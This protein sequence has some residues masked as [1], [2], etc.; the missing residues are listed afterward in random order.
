[1]A[2]LRL[3]ASYGHCM[4][5]S[6]PCH[7]AIE[8]GHMSMSAPAC[9]AVSP[10]RNTWTSHCLGMQAGLTTATRRQRWWCIRKHCRRRRSDRDATPHR[11]LRRRKHRSMCLEAC[12]PGH[13]RKAHREQQPVLHRLLAGASKE[14]S[15]YQGLAR[16]CSAVFQTRQS[17]LRCV[18][19]VHPACARALTRCSHGAAVP[20]RADGAGG[21]VVIAG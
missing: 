1:M 11:S 4:R 13:R 7:G 2:K 12:R 3:C 14:A 6:V 19:L 17:R 10:S 15:A 9:A 16:K 20:A 21:V 5:P 18:R 8:S